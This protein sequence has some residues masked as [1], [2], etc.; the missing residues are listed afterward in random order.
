ME[1]STSLTT[2]R[3]VAC[4][5]ATP[6]LTETEARAYLVQVPEWE[7]R[8]AKSMRRRFRFQ[9][10]AGAMAFVNRVAALA[11][12]EGHHPDILISYDRVRIDLTTHAIGCLSDN[13]FIT[14]AKIDRLTQ[15]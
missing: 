5:K 14:A 2:R 6:R 15:G 3:C 7:M 4:D 9:D 8:D 10:F 1:A 11:Q 13:D 12:E